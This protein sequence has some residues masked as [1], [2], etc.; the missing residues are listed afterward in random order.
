MPLFG[1]KSPPA[2]ADQKVEQYDNWKDF[3]KAIGQMN[4]NG[5]LVVSAFSSPKSVKGIFQ[6]GVGY[7]IIAVYERPKVVPSAE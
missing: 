4:L 6:N 1:S 5:W 2:A 3:Q 7:D